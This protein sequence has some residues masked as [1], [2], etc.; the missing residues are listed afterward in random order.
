MKDFLLRLS[1]LVFMALN[2]AIAYSAQRPTQIFTSPTAQTTL[3]E[4]YTSE[5]CSSCPPADRWL[6]G[7]KNDERL[8]HEV[9]PLAFH[10]DYWNYLGWK[11]RFAK[12]DYSVRQRLYTS[13]GFAGSVYTPGFFINSR[14]WR[15]WFSNRHYK[16]E[17]PAKVGTLSVTVRS[18]DLTAVY[19]PV[20]PVKKPL[21]LNVAVVGFDINSPINRGENQGKVFNHNFVVLEWVVLKETAAHR[22]QS[23]LD[24]LKLRQPHVGALA[25]WVS[26]ADD[27]TPLQ[28]T[29]GWFKAE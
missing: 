25:F 18:E 14:E 24:N 22:W 5:G 2:H 1:L 17:T 19:E 8:W 12:N 28:A 11:D 20:Q 27:P 9:I 16:P 15:G 23:H 29:A 4:L 21:L 6:S 10:V 3:I 13:K 7:W 26:T